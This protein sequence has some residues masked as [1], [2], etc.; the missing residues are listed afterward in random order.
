MTSRELKP[1]VP[2][3][4]QTI[5]TLIDFSRRLCQSLLNCRLSLPLILHLQL[6]EGS[7]SQLRVK[8][9]LWSMLQD[10]LL[11]LSCWL[12]MP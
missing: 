11:T 3:L 10:Q 2:Y 4:F 12:S 5:S 1:Q 8:I 7:H 9:Q 6:L